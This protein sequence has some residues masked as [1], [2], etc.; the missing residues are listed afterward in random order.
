MNDKKPTVGVVIVSYN[1]SEAVRITLASLR[2]AHNDTPYKV[3]LVDNASQETERAKIRSAM[4]AHI[5]EVGDAWRYI[6]QPKNL[7]FSG[8]NNVGIKAFLDDAEIS[9][10]AL[11]NSDVI[12]TD[13]WLDRLMAS[14]H[15][16]VSGVTN[17]ADSEQCVPVTYQFEL[18]DCLDHDAE[19]IHESIYRQVAE[20]ADGW[21][22][23]WHGNVVE[24][25]VTFFCVLVS[26]VACRKIGLLDEAFFPGGFE[27]DDYCVRA[28][29]A[30]FEI[31]LARDTF[32]H[33][34]GSASF[35]KLQYDYLSDK[36]KRNRECLEKKH[37]I[38]WQRRPEKP[39]VSF[40][41]DVEFALKHS[42]DLASRGRFLELYIPNLNRQINYFETEFNNLRALLQGASQPVPV[43]LAGQVAAAEIFGALEPLWNNVVQRITQILKGGA[44]TESVG[45]EIDADLQAIAQGIHQRVD[46][47]FAIHAFLTAQNAEQGGAASVVPLPASSAPPAITH[48]QTR[49]GRYVSALRKAFRFIAQFDGIVFFGGYFYP[50]R[51]SD[52]YFQR[53]QIVDRLF[54]DRW[55]LYVE[56]DSLKGRN[57]WFDRPEPGVLVLRVNGSKKRRALVRLLVLLAVL[58]SRKVYFHSVL[59]MFDYHFGAFLR[60]PFIKAAVDIHGVVPEEFRMHNDF[61]SALIYEN[62]ERNAV[63]R[64]GLVIVVTEAMRQYLQQK[65]RQALK[66]QSTCF[67]MFPSLTPAQAERPLFD[68]MPVVVYAGGLHK[69]QQ[70]PKM[71]DA[72]IK[73]AACCNHRFYTPEPEVVRAMLPAGLVDKVTVEA[74]A[75]AELMDL[76]SACHYGFILR[77]D[78][79]VNRVACPT[80]LVEYL[81]MGIVP[82]VDSEDIGDFKAMGMQFVRL[83]DFLGGILPDE[84]RRLEMAAANFAVYEALKRVR[85]AGANDIRAY[86]ID[87]EPRGAEPKG[88]SSIAHRMLP[89]HT[90]RGR[91]ARRL[92]RLLPHRPG[93]RACVVRQEEPRP[94]VVPAGMELSQ[95][96]CDILVQVDNFEAGGLENV[97]LDLNRVLEQAGYRIVLLVLGIRGAAV[98]R[99]Q[100]LGQTVVSCGYSDQSYATI[101]DQLQP[102]LVL[103]HYSLKGVVQCKHRAIPHV[104]IIHN[105]YMWLSAD[106]RR[107]FAKFAVDAHTCIAVSDYVRQYSVSKLGVPAEKCTVIPN[108]ID[109]SPFDSLDREQARARLRA[110]YSISDEEFV[111]LSVGSI[112]HQKNHI[113][114]IKAFEI[115]VQSCPRSR[116]LILGP[117]YE[118]DLMDEISS[119]IEKNGLQDKVLYCGTAKSAHEHMAMADS[120]VSGSFFE[121]SALTLLEAIKAN[122]SIAVSNVGNA[123]QYMS[124]PGFQIVDP[125]IDMLK[126]EACIL[127]MTSNPAFEQRLAEAMVRICKERLRPD[128]SREQLAALEKSHTYAQYVEM[129][130]E[131]IGP[132]S[133]VTPPVVDLQAS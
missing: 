42:D 77:E 17:K 11:L 51:Q 84:P 55:R 101:L 60:L 121:G 63:Q 103:A 72:I 16:I 86:F 9:H 74:K 49:L 123:S 33:H 36:A 10:I 28:R 81:A 104:Q 70:V 26:V 79:I 12:V 109:F 62:Q 3:I 125:A 59:R 118:Q 131:L 88:P 99:A 25:D 14:G 85:E 43:S 38:T 122:L 115:A 71:V 112:N 129:V 117:V 18:N 1:A 133:P 22:S 57:I 69:W 98:Q 126:Y 8:G 40:R 23:A 7:G 124:M 45:K 108:G 53:I 119:Y 75:H 94:I 96:K 13:H 73:T 95:M 97:A 107:E 56:G 110:Q 27:D 89:P 87:A 47:N 34:W 80:K 19:R 93:H 127:T 111:F 54:S 67:P 21:Y 64:A 106:Q 46:C 20:F 82:I 91:L 5:E 48:P 58:R 39:L 132:A 130:T 37:G 90:R 114:T 24:A 61:Y 32:L 78:I 128:F 76:Y 41:M 2:R 50:E 100:E 44:Y 4:H 30:G 116:L 66:A 68:G 102:K 15:D 113:G 83:T 35:G 29:Q 52:G 120:F 92:W 105:V 6:E 31:Y 65:F